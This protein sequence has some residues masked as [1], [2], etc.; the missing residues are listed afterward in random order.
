MSKARKNVII[1]A[2]VLLI[3]SAAVFVIAGLIRDKGSQGQITELKEAL[4]L[5]AGDRITFLYDPKDLHQINDSLYYIRI[6]L[7]ENE[8]SVGSYVVYPV[9]GYRKGAISSEQSGSENVIKLT[10]ELTV[11]SEETKKELL[12]G[13]QNIYQRFLDLYQKHYDS[14][15]YVDEGYTEE[16]MLNIIEMLKN[17]LSDESKVIMEQN[18]S[19]VTLQITSSNIHQTIRTA[20]VI[21]GVLCL[22]VLIYA[23]LGIRVRAKRLVLGTFGT[24]AAVIAVTPVVLRKDITT[25]ISLK[26]FCPGLYMARIDN[27][28]KLDKMLAYEP[29]SE[30]DMLNAM[31]K[32]LFYGISMSFDL[33]SI[34]CS[35]FSAQTEDGTH[36]LGRNFD[37]D[38]TDGTIIYTA[39]KDGYRSIGVCDMS[40]IN[41]T[42]E[43]KFADV[44]SLPG[45]AI[46]RAFPYITFDGMNEKGLG[47][48]ILSLDKNPSHPDTEKPDTYMLLAIRAILDTCATTDE[49]AEL[50]NSYDVHSMAIFNY[51]LFITDKSGHSIVAEWVD[52][53]LSI[54]DAEYV[55]NDYLTTP[56][57]IKSDERYDTLEK[58]ITACNDVMTADEAMKLLSEVKQAYDTT[59]TQWSC[60]YD[61]DHFK[62]YIVSDMDWEH[63]YEITP[64]SF[65]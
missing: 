18:I 32:E 1:T 48:A 8:E 27:E 11:T 26:Q 45:R 2:L 25:M 21:F 43:N 10:A 63:K 62:V 24:I 6:V 42:G 23:L 29:T 36:L 40:V 5:K 55:C 56:Y 58:N 9:T 65:K 28:Y 35:A 54:I 22:L 57:L 51:H 52:D 34:G 15:K 64:E 39:P 47:I 53:Q 14:G 60:V 20:A 3:V 17:R 59:Q 41:L 38:N 31:S 30:G 46:S 12:S 50:L 49:A 13:M 44:L 33:S 37:L 61:L 7:R 19:P 16:Y 4:D